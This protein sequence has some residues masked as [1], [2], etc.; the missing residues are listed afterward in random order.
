MQYIETKRVD[1]DSR[2][3][4]ANNALPAGTPNGLNELVM[5]VV[6]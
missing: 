3:T 1:I 5:L 6:R 2:Y 4:A